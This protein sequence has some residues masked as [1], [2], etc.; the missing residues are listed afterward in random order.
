MPDWREEAACRFGGGGRADWFAEA[1]SS[2]AKNAQAI[3]RTCPVARECLRAALVNG[4]EYGIWGGRE[5]GKLPSALRTRYRMRRFFACRYCGR[6]AVQPGHGGQR[7][8]CSIACREAAKDL[9]RGRGGQKY[10]LI[11]A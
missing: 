6:H 2:A 10:G 5:I 8:Y 4:E 9:R 7:R 1:G 3:C 11:S